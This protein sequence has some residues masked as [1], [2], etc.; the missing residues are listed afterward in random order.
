MVLVGLALGLFLV[1]LGVAGLRS[2][3]L[4]AD[5]VPITFAGAA[6]ALSIGGGA[7]MLVLVLRFLRELPADLA[8]RRVASTEGFIRK[9]SS[10]SNTYEGGSITTYHYRIGRLRFDVPRAGY[11]ALD[12]RRRYRVYYLPRTKIVVNLDPI[13][14]A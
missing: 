5:Q 11:E 9:S 12:T 3:Q 1:G 6:A 7:L 2:P 13:S 4:F 8:G 10:T 14:A